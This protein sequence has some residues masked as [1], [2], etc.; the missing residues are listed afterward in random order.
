LHNNKPFDIVGL[1]TNNTLF[2]VNKTFANTKENK[3]HKA[4]FIAKKQE[5]LTVTTPLKFNRT[6]IQLVTDKITLTQEQQC[7]NLSTITTKII[8]STRTQ[9]TTQ[10]LSPKEQYIAQHTRGAYIA[11]VCQPKTSFNLSFATQI[12]NPTKEDTK[13]LNK[14][15][16]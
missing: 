9:G 11:S 12:T 6:I 4:K 8:T 1:Q 13:T 14:R 7:A 15:L 10:A 16:A 3:L 2:L 5:K